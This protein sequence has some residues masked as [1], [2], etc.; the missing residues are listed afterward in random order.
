ML[1][2]SQDAARLLD[3]TRSNQGIPE[4]YGV[5]VFGQSDPQGRVQVHLAFTE[6]PE[7]GDHVIEQSGT[8]VYVAPEVAEPLEGALIDV[9]EQAGS[10]E[11]VIRPQGEKA[12]PA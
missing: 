4:N 7:D 9:E 12:P 3:Q 11:L 10:S 1:Q 2:V 8:E 6:Q 5:R